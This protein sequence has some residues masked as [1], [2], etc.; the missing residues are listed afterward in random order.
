MKIGYAFRRNV[1]YPF[2][3]GPPGLPPT[4]LLDGYLAKLR[5]IGF[6]GVELPGASVS[7]L[8]EDAAKALADRLRSAEMPCVAIRGG[9]GMSNPANATSNRK[10]W[11]QLLEVASWLGAGI[12]NGALGETYRDPA[13]RGL[14]TGETYTQG[15]SRHATARDYE[16]D[17]EA[18]AELCD[19]AAN[20]GTNIAIEVHQHTKVDNS[21]S[22]L[23]V[24]NLVGRDNF[25]I[26]PDLG[27]I[28][29]NYYE[30]EET[31]EAAIAAL[32]PHSIYWHC[33]NLVRTDITELEHSYF[34]RV[35]LPVGDIDYRFAI[36][37]MVEARYDGYLMVEGARAGD[38]LH[39]DATSVRYAREILDELGA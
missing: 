34:D 27:N 30:P 11:E 16:I 21:W 8:S 20:H 39:A 18:L 32:A 29:W 33:K 10:G 7:G 14:S 26:N 5:E 6:E 17:A 12:V 31:T 35:P 9:G 28:Y 2:H 22:A 37:A 1:F 19:L 3:D 25:G 4:D 15:T 24:I 38:Q 13:G 36:S 23:H